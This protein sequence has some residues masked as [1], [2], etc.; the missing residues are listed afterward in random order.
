M[1]TLTGKVIENTYP[2]LIKTS[3]EAAIDGTLKNLQDGLGNDL[4][5]QVSSTEVN[6]TGTV[7]GVPEGPQ[8]PVGP[9]G[10]IGLE[11]P[12]GLQGD[13]GVVQSIVAGTNVTVDA[14]DPANPIVS[15]SGGGGAA[16]L[17]SGTGTDS[18]RSADLLT[19]TPADAR[20]QFA[21]ALGNNAIAGLTGSS[22]I[23]YGIAI[24]NNASTT[25]TNAFAV[26]GIS[27]GNNAV[28]VNDNVS[29]GNN[30]N[31]NQEAVAIGINAVATGSRAV[32]IGR[33]SNAQ[34]NSVALGNFAGVN[35]TRSIGI[36][37]SGLDV[38]NIRSGDSIVITSGGYGGNTA[39][40]ASNSIVIGSAF[41]SANRVTQADG[42]AIGKS[43]TSSAVGAVALGADV[44]AAI[45]N[46]VS[47]K[48]LETQTVGGGITM[49]SPNGTGYKLTVDDAGVLVITAI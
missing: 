15:A 47:V 10:P 46:T 4:P 3:D 29:I 34:G 35:A 33:N 14:T 45:A 21:I 19:T 38:M 49:Y 26:A 9:Q 23:P 1:A 40:A 30:T 31:A 44:T 48:E 12:Q 22:V 25:P 5:I 42:I 11:G 27:I 36:S 37:C 17:V 28:G 41:S 18:M 43:T 13:P 6:F 39:S 24:G 7:T 32:A 20:S 16:G 2:G 8:G